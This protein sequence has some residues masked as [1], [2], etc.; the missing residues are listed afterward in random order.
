MA[1]VGRIRLGEQE[2]YVNAKGETRK[3]AAKRDTFRLTSRDHTR[4]EAAQTIYPGELRKWLNPGTKQQ[5][6]ELLT[7]TD[8]LRIMVIPGQPLS[9]WYELYS[10]GGCLRRCDGARTTTPEDGEC[11]CPDDPKERAELAKKGKAC[12]PTSRLAV[13]LPD[14]PGIGCWR[15]ESHGYYA[16]VELAGMAELLAHVTALGVML[17]AR[18]RIDRRSSI[19]GGQT[20]RYQVP[21]IEIEATPNEVRALGSGSA[22]EGQRALPP[23]PPSGEPQAPKESPPPA[24]EGAGSDDTH[25]G[26]ASQPPEMAAV[27][28]DLAPLISEAQRRYVFATARAKGL[29][30]DALREVIERVTGQT[31]T[32]AI[33]KSKM[34]E[35]IAEIEEAKS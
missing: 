15:L 20:R 33:P 14:V 2:E 31:S 9:Q 26:H 11:L 4:L 23:A 19:S 30:E 18:L 22:S 1:E 5:E 10:G 24:A 17:P 27:E 35:L 34:D 13:M 8:E 12:K 7:Q 3:R 21:V 28:S 6:Y 25:A 32:A 16:A 29:D